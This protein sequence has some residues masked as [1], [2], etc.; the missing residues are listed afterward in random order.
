MSQLPLILRAAQQILDDYHPEGGY[1][2]QDA[3]PAATIRGLERFRALA[4]AEALRAIR[5]TFEDERTGL[6][7]ALQVHEAWREAAEPVFARSRAA[8]RS[9]LAGLYA[10]V[11]LRMALR[12][13]DQ[14]GLAPQDAV[15]AETIADWVR[16]HLPEHIDSIVET[17]REQVAEALDALPPEGDREAAL[18]R[19]YAGSAAQRAPLIA[20]TE[21]VAASGLGGH[22]AAVAASRQGVQATRTWHSLLDGRERPAH[23]EADGQRREMDEA[24]VIGGERLMFPG[25]PSLGA[26][27]GMLIGC[28]CFQTFVV[29]A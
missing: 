29:A 11:G 14:S 22:V 2:R 27:P 1:R 9:L 17:S 15:W 18:D 25:D 3:D 10:R 21:V 26:S 5:Q 24:Y 4:G 23:G 12:T 19:V 20:Q 16:R 13:W 28:R 7:L 8:W 6:V